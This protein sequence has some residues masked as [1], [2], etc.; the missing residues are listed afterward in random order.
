MNRDLRILLAAVPVVAAVLL[1]GS[2]LM[3]M[4]VGVLLYPSRRLRGKEWPPGVL[5]TCGGLGMIMLH[6]FIDL[7]F[8]CP[9]LMQHWL[10]ILATTFALAFPVDTRHRPGRS[11]HSRHAH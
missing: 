4:S 5:F 2:L 9:A 7:P 10:V 8:R 1:V 11:L 3:V 6:G